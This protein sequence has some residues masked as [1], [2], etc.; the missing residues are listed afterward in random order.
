MSALDSVIAR[1]E[2]VNTLDEVAERVSVGA[3]YVT[4][5]PPVSSILSGTWIGHPLHPILT[6]LPIGSWTSAFVLDLVGGRRS[7]KAAQSLVGL[8]ILAAV[9]TALTGLADW[10]D[11][12]GATRR[13]GTF[14]ALTNSVGLGCYVLSWRARRRG[15]HYRGVAWAMAGATAA[16]AAASLGGHLVYR[17]GTGVDVNAHAT[18]PEDWTDATSASSLP[19]GEGRYVEAGPAKVLALHDG[20]GG[21]H[22]IGARCSHRDGPLEEGEFADGCVTCPWHKSRFR[23]DDGSVVDGPATAPQPRYDVRERDG[24]VS[25]RSAARGGDPVG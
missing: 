25:V 6:D 3:S 4:H 21:W 20:P 5:R 17:L 24:T 18:G 23:L 8:G 12:G 13:V 14:H 7:R 22:G 1:L 16:T 2:Q 9:P 19:G 11:T 15:H 10:A